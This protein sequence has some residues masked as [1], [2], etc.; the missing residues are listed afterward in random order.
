MRFLPGSLRAGAV[1]AL[2]VATVALASG[3]SA[4]AVSAPPGPQFATLKQSV[5]ATAGHRTGPRLRALR[6]LW[7][8]L[9]GDGDGQSGLETRRLAMPALPGRLFLSDPFQQ[10]TD[11]D[12]GWR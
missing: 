12:D 6:Q 1:A 5:R 8:R 4:A 9:S 3:L 7:H 2:G 11:S 10:P